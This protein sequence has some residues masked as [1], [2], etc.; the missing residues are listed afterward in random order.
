MKEGVTCSSKRSHIPSCILDEARGWK[1]EVDL[2][3]KLVFPDIVQTKLRPDIV[4]WSE[5]GKKLVIVELTVP[6]ESRC[7][8]AFERKRGKYT[9]LQELCNQR[10]SR[11]WLYP[12]E[13]GTR[14]FAAQSF[15]RM[16]SAV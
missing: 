6:W 8:E 10:G 11:T 1:M 16:L 5:V 15:C 9:E 7:E 13:V 2:G 14:G 3:K 4:L 12:V